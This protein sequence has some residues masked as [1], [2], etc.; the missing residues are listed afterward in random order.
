MKGFQGKKITTLWSCGGKTV[1]HF[2]AASQSD[3]IY[4]VSI[5]QWRHKRLNRHDI[6]ATTKA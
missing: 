2:G 1:C 6:T 4:Q 3:G 5:S